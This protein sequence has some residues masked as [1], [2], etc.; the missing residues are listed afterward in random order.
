VGVDGTS[1]D[2]EDE[3]GQ[4]LACVERFVEGETGREFVVQDGRG[5]VFRP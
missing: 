4:I 5:V 1:A 3:E 2:C